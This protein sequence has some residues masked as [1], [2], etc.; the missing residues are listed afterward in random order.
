MRLDLVLNNR[1]AY[2]YEG[3]TS[4][5]VAAVL[6][7]KKIPFKVI[8]LSDGILQDYIRYLSDN[9]PNYMVSFT[10]LFPY[11]CP[12]CDVVQVP[13]FFWTMQ[14]LCEAAHFLNSNFGKIG[15][16]YPCTLAKTVYL[17][18]G[19]ESTPPQQ[20]LFDTVFFSPLIDLHDLEKM[21]EDFFP[22]HMIAIIKKAL[23]TSLPPYEAVMCA[24][25]GNTEPISLNHLLDAVE[26]HQRA[27]RAY[28]VITSF[29]GGY[30]D[31]FGAHIGN[32]WLKRLPCAQWV[33]LHHTLPYTEHMEVLKQSK[34]II[35]DPL[36][37]HWYLPAV[38]AGCKPLGYIPEQTQPL[39]W[40]KQTNQLIEQ[41]L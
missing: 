41:L 39:S 15:L 23:A 7:K 24:L 9:P 13:Q 19:V 34:Q 14:S 38:A 20:R 6:K 28:D 8:Y 3:Y 21:W 1:T 36:E 27:K 22:K 17:P 5:K 26:T 18:H 2:S 11:D 40:E 16:P 12:F 37:P 10:D 33:R 29:E 30:I 31:V 4:R 35:I 25:K 32:N